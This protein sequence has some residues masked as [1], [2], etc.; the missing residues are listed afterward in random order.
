MSVQ[1]CSKMSIAN[2]SIPRTDADF[3]PQNEISEEVRKM[4]SD[5]EKAQPRNIFV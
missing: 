5:W 1:G 3:Q 4:L 2:H